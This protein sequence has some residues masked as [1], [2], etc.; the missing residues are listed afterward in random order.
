V[1]NTWYGYGKQ[2]F[3]IS[4][5]LAF[6]KA[7]RKLLNAFYNPENGYTFLRL[8]PE[9]SRGKRFPGLSHDSL[10]TVVSNLP[11]L[12]SGED[13]IPQGLRDTHPKHTVPK[14]YRRNASEPSQKWLQIS[15]LAV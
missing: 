8:R 12:S 5:G 1:F 15:L 4:R 13:L 3:F 6:W 11:E 7:H 14:S 2:Q 10:T 9:V